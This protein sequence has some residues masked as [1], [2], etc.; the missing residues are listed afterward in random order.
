MQ[1]SQHGLRQHTPV[2]RLFHGGLEKSAEPLRLALEFPAPD[3]HV[4]GRDL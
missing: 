2:V 1:T 4:D 3:C